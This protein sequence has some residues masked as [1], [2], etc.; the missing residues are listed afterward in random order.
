MVRERI[1]CCG[2]ERKEIGSE[3]SW[4]IEYLPGHF[5]RIQH[6]R[7]KYACSRCEQAAAPAPF[8]LFKRSARG[9]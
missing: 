2:E 7:K 8:S 3:G 9:P 1:V 4:Q 6:V 5:E